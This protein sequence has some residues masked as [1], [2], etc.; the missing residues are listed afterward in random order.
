MDETECPEDAV[1]VDG[2]CETCT[3]DCSMT[4]LFPAED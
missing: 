4:V 3:A 1:I 2:F